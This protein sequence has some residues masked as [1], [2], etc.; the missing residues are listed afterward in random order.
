MAAFVLY[1]DLA[2]TKQYMVFAATKDEAEALADELV[3]ED[4][5]KTLEQEILQAV[6]EQIDEQD[7]ELLEEDE[8]EN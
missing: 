6:A 3:S 8:Y 7:C 1:V 5:G 2:V 4:G